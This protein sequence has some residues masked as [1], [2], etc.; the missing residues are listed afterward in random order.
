MV[1]PTPL[2]FAKGAVIAA[3]LLFWAPRTTEAG[4]PVCWGPATYV[5]Y[6]YG[7]PVYPWLYYPWLYGQFASTPV[8]TLGSMPYGMIPGGNPGA[9]EVAPAPATSATLDLIVPAN[10]EVWLDGKK[11]TQTGTTRSFTTQPLTSGQVST[12]ELRVT[13]NDK[14]GKAVTE[15]RKVQLRGAQRVVLNLVP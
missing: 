3:A 8:S 7:D 14:A 2:L 10:A 1:R 6:Y 5:G 9:V 13:F 15:Q 11:T 12:Q 4:W